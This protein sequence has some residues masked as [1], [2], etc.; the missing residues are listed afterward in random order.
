MAKLSI[1]DLQL[2]GKRVF[3]RVDFN[4]PIKDGVIRDDTR[5]RASIPT[6]QLRPGPGAPPIVASH[7]GPTEWQ[8]EHRPT[9]SR[10]WPTRL[11]QLLDRH[12]VFADDCVGPKV[13]AAVDETPRRPTRCC[14]SRTSDSI[15]RKRRTTRVFRSNL[16]PSLTTTSTMRLARRTG[17]MPQSRGSRHFFKRPAA[18]LLME[19]ELQ[20]SRPCARIAGAAV[21]RHPRRREGVGQDRGDR[22]P[23]R[24]GGPADHRRRD[25]VYLFEVARCPHRANRWWRTTS[26]RRRRSI[27]ADAAGERRRRSRCRWIT[28]SPSGSRPT[29]PTRCWRSTTPRSATGWGRHRSEDDRGV[30]AHAARRA[31]RRLERTDGRLRDRRVRRRHQCPRAAVADVRGTTIVGGG[32]SISAIRRPAWPTASRISPPAAA[33]RSNFSADARCPASRRSRTNR[34]GSGRRSSMRTPLIA[35]NWKMFKTVHEAV[36][37]A[38][39]FKSARQGRHRRGHRPCAAVHGGACCGR[40]GA[41]TRISRVAAQDVF[42]ER[43]GAFTGEVS[44]AMMQ[45]AGAEYVIIGHSERRRL[46]GDTDVDGEPQADRGDWRR[47][48]ADCLHWR[49]ARGAGIRARRSRCSTG[50]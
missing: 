36:A 25:G 11:A 34:A 30:P 14:C 5:I 45:E 29:R 7:L 38:K 35:G 15:R 31:Y 12:V 49:D 10:R 28:S 4:V 17:R 2:Q 48:D 22:E 47:I 33:R 44:A 40:C 21:R 41:R 18:G 6:L 8:G 16:P 26:S 42:W 24:Q 3:I 13:A 20:V 23:A 46:F 32:D 43:E 1:R 27:T 9:A 19:Q 37:F 50:S 39:E